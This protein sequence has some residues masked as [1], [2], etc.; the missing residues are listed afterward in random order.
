M[1]ALHLVSRLPGQLSPDSPL[2]AVSLYQDTL[3]PS[4]A[5]TQLQHLVRFSRLITGNTEAGLADFD[6][7]SLRARH[8]EFVLPLLKHKG[9]A[10]SVVNATLSA[11]RRVARWAWHLEQMREEDYRRIKDVPGVRQGDER[12]RP[13]RALSGGEIVSLFESCERAGNLCGLRDACLITLLYA[14]GLRLDEACRVEVKDYSTRSHIISVRGKGQKVRRVFFGP[15]GAR[16]ALNAWLRARGGEPGPLLCPVE[17]WPDR[18]VIRRLSGT[19]LARALARR[20]ER[21]QVAHFTPHDLRR[22]L[23]THLAAAGEDIDTVRRIFGHSDALT[24]Q[25]YIMRGEEAQRRAALKVSVQ[26]RSGRS[27]RRR[28]GKRGSN[29]R[30]RLRAKL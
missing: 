20:A 9:Y 18:I 1:G 14:G 27:R 19:G 21:A 3:S 24:T 28:K 23:G 8:V 29:W 7:R 11:L 4:G 12:R 10:P 17:R 16:R 22:S 25:R 13:A 30:A 5:R 2:A 26:F 15:G 6:W